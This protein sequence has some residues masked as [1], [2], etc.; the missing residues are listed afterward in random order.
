MVEKRFED[1][2]WCPVYGWVTS[3]KHF[4]RLAGKHSQSQQM[5]TRTQTHKA[6]GI[7]T[8]TWTRPQWPWW[9]G[10][11]T[12]KSSTPENRHICDHGVTLLSSLRDSDVMVTHFVVLCDRCVLPFLW[13]HAECSVRPNRCR[14]PQTPHLGQ[15]KETWA[16]TKRS[17]GRKWQFSTLGNNPICFLT[18]SYILAGFL[19]FEY[20][21][22]SRVLHSA[23]WVELFLN[24]SDKPE[25]RI[26]TC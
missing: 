9:R 14:S 20:Y 16:P 8:Q 6:L 12:P 2:L 19:S 22:I 17:H 13:R 10:A 3:H 1:S 11:G 18:E 23:D 7:L 15:Q 4:D 21:I 25:K 5:D 24:E 26:W